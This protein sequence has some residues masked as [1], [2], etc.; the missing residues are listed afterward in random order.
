MCNI[1]KI[2]VTGGAGFIGSSIV[3]MLLS[4]KYEV[5]ILDNMSTSNMNKIKHIN[6]EN[7]CTLIKGD[8]R[9]EKLVKKIVKDIDAIFHQAAITDISYSIKYPIVT[10]EV[11]IK[12]TLNLLE[13]CLNS[14]VERFIFASSA[15]VYGKKNTL[16]LK[17]IMKVNPASSYA[18]SKVASEFFVHSYNKMYGLKTTCLRYFNVYGIRSSKN[19]GVIPIFINHILK[20]KNPIIYGD[21]NQTR[22]FINVKDVARA[23]ILT[24]S[25]NNC[26]GKNINIGS[27]KSISINNLV[28]KILKILNK[29][30]L[31]PIYYEK[32]M[33]DIKHGYADIRK[34]K[35]L[36]NFNPEIS[37]E[38]GLSET[39]KY[40][41][42]N[43]QY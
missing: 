18:I 11:N 10:N 25:S 31:K 12:G 3:E 29:S 22:D 37:L 30:I 8:I 32:R 34:A 23:N 19:Q 40:I 1:E 14:N 21:G 36:L 16:P 9:D 27:G 35:N 26:I 13:S 6:N 17:E 20:N 7:L 42:S 15:S 33:G 24:L 2:L 5:I 38:K 4:K 39:I 43:E 41:R 28:Y